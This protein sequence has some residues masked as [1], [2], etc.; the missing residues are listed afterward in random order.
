MLYQ[1]S[2]FL[3]LSKYSTKQNAALLYTYGI[4]PT[5]GSKE[6]GW[7]MLSSPELIHDLPDL[8]LQLL[9]RKPEQL[10]IIIQPPRSGII[11]AEQMSQEAGSEDAHV[12][13]ARF[14]ERYQPLFFFRNRYM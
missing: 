3:T 7:Q 12:L 14:E 5:S 4:L 13:T 10:T 1:G 6:S 8:L 11:R 9:R 2:Y